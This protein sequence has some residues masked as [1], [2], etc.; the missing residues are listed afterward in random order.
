MLSG[1]GSKGFLV[2]INLNHLKR[3]VMPKILELYE[4]L[5]PVLGEKASKDL[6]DAIQELP[7]EELRDIKDKVKDVEIEIKELRKDLVGQIK[8]LHVE[9][10][11]IEKGLR[12]DMASMEKGLSQKMATMEKSIR[13]DMA[14]MEK[15][16]REEIKSLWVEI[17]SLDKRIERHF[18]TT[19][20]LF[21][22]LLAYLA[23]SNPEGLKNVLGIF[24]LVK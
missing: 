10:V 1:R 18:Y 12:L 24:G 7:K 13:E 2:N 20:I 14:S 15:G 19:I 11:S 9:Q 5:K 8:G 3:A 21:G 17:K 16:L 22:V 6:V 23:T 4:E